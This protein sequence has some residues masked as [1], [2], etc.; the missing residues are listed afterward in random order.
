MK[1][2]EEEKKRLENI[3]QTMLHD[4][5]VLKM[6]EV[7]MHRGSNCYLHSFKVAKK[8]FH[9]ALHYKHVDL[10]AILYAAI[11]H[12]YYLYDWRK[13]KTKKKHHGARHPYIAAAQAKRDFAISELTSKIIKSH[14]W[15]INIK[16]FPSTKEAR[17]LSYSDKDIAL[18]EALCSKKYKAKREEKYYN[19][20]SKLFD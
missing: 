17:I 5:K 3:Y 12:D 4:G 15:P 6:K 18:T 10:E 11:L 20:I 14:M 2:N 13:D 8:A 7:P 1:L 9:H 19:Y 16:E